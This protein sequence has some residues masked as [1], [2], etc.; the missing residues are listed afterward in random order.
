MYAT[1][2]INA[3]PRKG[4]IRKRV[5]CRASSTVRRPS[6]SASRGASIDRMLV[7]PNSLSHEPQ[8]GQVPVPLAELEP[9]ADEELV[10]DRE[11]DV[12]DGEIVDEPAVRPVEERSDVE[13]RRP[14]DAQ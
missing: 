11:S 3:G 9:V 1:H 5:R 12:P 8:V 7:G 10:R 14:A 6:G 2:A 4:R 13:R